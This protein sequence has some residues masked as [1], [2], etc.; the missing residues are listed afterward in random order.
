MESKTE[1][2]YGCT[3]TSGNKRITKQLR[4]TKRVE[5]YEFKVDSR[6]PFCILGVDMGVVSHSFPD[7]RMW[8]Y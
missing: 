2:P 8:P 4:E 3:M 7:I 6:N 1:P 5:R